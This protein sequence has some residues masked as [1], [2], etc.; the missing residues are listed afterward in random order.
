MTLDSSDER[1]TRLKFVDVFTSAAAVRF[2]SSDVSRLY[3]KI[4][5]LENLVAFPS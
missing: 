1:P 2:V 3:L 5:D 4:S